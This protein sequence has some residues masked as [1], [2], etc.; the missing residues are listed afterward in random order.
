MREEREEMEKTMQQMQ[1]VFREREA[2]YERQIASLKEEAIS[3]QRR[4]QVCAASVADFRCTTKLER[5]KRFLSDGFYMGVRALQELGGQH[6]EAELLE[7][8]LARSPAE[9]ISRW[10]LERRRAA[11]VSALSISISKRAPERTRLEQVSRG[12][13]AEGLCCQAGLFRCPHRGGADC[14][15]I[16]MRHLG[17]FD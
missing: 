8:E 10:V 12:A 15:L 7:G 5:I 6:A 9:I 4:V 13:C 14:Q 16:E 1:K 11:R 2:S 17:A 3:A